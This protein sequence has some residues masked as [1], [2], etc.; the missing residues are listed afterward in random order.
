VRFS[1]AVRFGGEVFCGVTPVA[2]VCCFAWG[3]GTGYVTGA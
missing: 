1:V 3:D 2:P